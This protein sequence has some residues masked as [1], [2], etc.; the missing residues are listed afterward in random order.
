MTDADVERRTNNDRLYQ[1][2]DD[3]HQAVFRGNGKPGLVTRVGVL[4]DRDVRQASKIAAAWGGAGT[5]IGAV[6]VAVLAYFGVR[7]GQGQ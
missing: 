2:V 4:E 6:V 1:M 7:P 5:A 3:I